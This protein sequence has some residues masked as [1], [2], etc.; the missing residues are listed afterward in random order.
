MRI[1]DWS[2][3][4]C[5]SDLAGSSAGTQ[6]AFDEPAPRER[7]PFELVLLLAQVAVSLAVGVLLVVRA[8]RLGGHATAEIGREPCRERVCKSVSLSVAAAYLT[9]YTI[10]IQPI[11]AYSPTTYNHN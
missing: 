6:P 10:Q 3:D 4:V 7:S 2:S 5:S 8:E 11:H 1:S 9:K